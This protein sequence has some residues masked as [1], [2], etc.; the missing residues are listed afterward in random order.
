MFP[1]PLQQLFNRQNTRFIFILLAIA[2]FGL[3]GKNISFEDEINDELLAL[4]CAADENLLQQ[5]EENVSFFKTGKTERCAVCPISSVSR[6]SIHD[7][8]IMT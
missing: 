2:S 1:N 3:I 5:E 6:T 4:E 8:L 7:K